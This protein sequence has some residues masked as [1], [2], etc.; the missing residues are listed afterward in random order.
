MGGWEGGEGGGALPRQPNCPPERP[1]F[2]TFLVHD[3]GV[4]LRGLGQT[5]EFTPVGAER[6]E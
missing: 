3:D 5:E 1:T 6:E 4:V 2:E